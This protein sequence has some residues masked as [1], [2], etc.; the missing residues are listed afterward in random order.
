MHIHT[1]IITYTRTRMQKQTNTNT[2]QPN[3]I[4]TQLLY[5]KLTIKK[6]KH[7]PPFVLLLLTNF[8][9]YIFCLIRDNIFYLDMSPAR[10]QTELGSTPAP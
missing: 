4:N 10:G 7:L 5:Y 3:T 2:Y 1:R 6:Q 9:K 8:D